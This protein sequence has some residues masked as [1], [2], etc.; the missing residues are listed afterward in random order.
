MPRICNPH[1]T[2][3]AYV[4]CRICAAYV[5]CTQLRRLLGTWI[6]LAMFTASCAS[7]CRCCMA[8]ASANAVLALMPAAAIA[9]AVLLLFA[10]Y[11]CC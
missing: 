11:C 8:V 7:C 4:I 10:L 5:K 9:V 6:Q 1:M 3:A 2:Y